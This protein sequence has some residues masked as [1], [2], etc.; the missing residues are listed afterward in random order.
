MKYFSKE[1]KG[2]QTRENGP[3]ALK[4]II[5]KCHEENISYLNKGW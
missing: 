4:P 1:L 5:G 2:P 3:G